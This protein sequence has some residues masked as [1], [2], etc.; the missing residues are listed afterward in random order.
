MDGSAE[1]FK[2]KNEGVQL[3]PLGE[4]PLVLDGIEDTVPGSDVG[5][6]GQIVPHVGLH[7]I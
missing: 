7:E 6:I 2:V 1:G 3:Q 5:A 4:P